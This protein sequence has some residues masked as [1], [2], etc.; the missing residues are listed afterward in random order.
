MSAPRYGGA[1]RPPRR[2][3]GGMPRAWPDH[4]GAEGPPN[5]GL[6]ARRWQVCAARRV[7]ARD[8]VRKHAQVVGRARGV[9]CEALLGRG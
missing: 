9:A 8:T 3:P 6:Q 5:A 7:T 2:G 1:I 4:A